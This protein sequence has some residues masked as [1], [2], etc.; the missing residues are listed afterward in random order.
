[1]SCKHSP[2]TILWNK[3]NKQTPRKYQFWSRGP[4]STAHGPCGILEL[5]GLVFAA[6]VLA[7]VVCTCLLLILLLLLFLFLLLM[8]VFV[9]YWYYCCCCSCSCCWCCLYLFSINNIAATVLV[10][11]ANVVLCICFLLVPL[12]LLLL[13]LLFCHR[14]SSTFPSQFTLT[15]KIL[16]SIMIPKEFHI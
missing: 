13:L 9:F 16:L 15:G 8:F 3:L 10:L 6:P 14:I 7:D 11:A 12:W 5:F 1:M 4:V 2:K